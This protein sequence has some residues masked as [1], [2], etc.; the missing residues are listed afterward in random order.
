MITRTVDTS[1]DYLVV[2]T[3]C[4]NPTNGTVGKTV[5]RADPNVRLNDYEY[6]LKFWLSLKESRVKKLIF[7]ENSGYSLNSLKAISEKHNIWN[8]KCEFISLN[9]NEVPFGLHYGFAEF[10]LLDLGLEKS[11]IFQGSDYFIKV[12][13]RYRFPTISRLLN[14]L[15]QGY[16]VAADT[17]EL[18]RFVP[19]P[20]HNVT[21]GL[22]IFAV[23][24]YQKYIR[25]IYKEMQPLPRRAFVEDILYDQLISMR[26]DPGVILRWPCNCEPDGIG[27]NGFSY[28]SSKKRLLSACR[29]VGRIMFPYW[30]F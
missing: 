2:M 27:G 17:R 24:F 28:S 30:W 11:R 7:I 8:R 4:I 13:G 12:T 25:E 14:L 29:A 9:C 21:V 16:K 23:E 10:K 19:Y 6:G 22:I 26:N 1:S 5:Y 3:A 18:S 20:R 15:P